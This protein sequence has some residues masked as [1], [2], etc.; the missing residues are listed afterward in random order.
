MF[1]GLDRYYFTMLETDYD[2]YGIAY[3]CRNLPDGQSEEEIRIGSRKP[4]LDANI[5]EKIDKIIDEYFDR[6]MLRKIDHD[7]EKC[8]GLKETFFSEKSD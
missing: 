8:K 4:T 6:S 7:L 1:D 2:N 5:Q 3:A